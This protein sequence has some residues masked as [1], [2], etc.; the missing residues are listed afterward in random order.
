MLLF[1]K[2]GTDIRLP[3]A[4]EQR[5]RDEKSCAS[6][7]DA[8]READ[9]AAKDSNIV[10]TTVIDL[11]SDDDPSGHDPGSGS[12]SDVV[13]V[14]GLHYVKAV[15]SGGALANLPKRNSQPSSKILEKHSSLNSSRSSKSV[16]G[17]SVGAQKQQSN[18]DSRKKASV[19]PSAKLQGDWQCTICTLINA[20]A[21]LQCDACTTRRPVDDDEGW[22]CLVCGETGNSHQH[23]SCRYCGQVKLHD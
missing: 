16:M 20:A 17:H 9:T 21:S 8:M 19:V 15:E 12:D 13:I 4:A 6:G 10:K 1:L 18:S 3:Q 22:S 11:T 14:K 2:F 7:A 23:W 5:I